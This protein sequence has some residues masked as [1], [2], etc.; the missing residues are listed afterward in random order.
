MTINM[1][2][3][4]LYKFLDITFQVLYFAL[5]IR[6]L[7]SWIPHNRS[8]PIIDFLYQLTDPLLRPFQNIVPS[9]R[10]GIDL[11]PLFAFLALGFIRKV[12]FQILF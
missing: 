10:I 1:V 6:V 9:W 11:S 3:V 12:L 5:L 7:I 2:Y 8:H 4:L